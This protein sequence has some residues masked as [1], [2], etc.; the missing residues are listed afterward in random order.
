[1]HDIGDY[2]DGVVITPGPM[3]IE[4]R[5]ATAGLSL[6]RAARATAPKLGERRYWDEIILRLTR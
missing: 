3:A 1:V 2:N 6:R 4:L 5:Q